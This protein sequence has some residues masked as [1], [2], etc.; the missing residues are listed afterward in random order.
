MRMAAE[1]GLIDV[2]Q[3]LLDLPLERGVD[4][5]AEDNF[6]F[7]FAAKHGQ[8]NVVQLLLSLSPDRRP[9]RAV[10]QD[11]LSASLSATSVLL[12]DHLAEIE[13]APKRRRARRR[14]EI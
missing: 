4:L 7:R 9:S 2:V 1:V 14:A 8:T 3:L 10:V 13:P 12:A 6:A 11:A 5:A